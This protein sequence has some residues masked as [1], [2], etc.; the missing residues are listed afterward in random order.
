[1]FL[2]NNIRKYK[3]INQ[4][5]VK[6]FEFYGIINNRDVN[7]RIYVIV[8]KDMSCCEINVFKN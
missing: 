4:F 2:Y 5:E 8:M 7:F 3:D 1:M 6:Y